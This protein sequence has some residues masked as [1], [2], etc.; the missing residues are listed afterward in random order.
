MAL[1]NAYKKRLVIRKKITFHL[2]RNLG[3]ISRRK[4]GQYSTTNFVNQMLNW[5]IV[6]LMLIN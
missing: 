5:I 6:N 4:R 1:I 2:R 3:K